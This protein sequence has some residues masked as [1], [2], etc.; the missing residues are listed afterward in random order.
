MAQDC[1]DHL[2]RSAER[3]GDGVG[4]GG[5]RVR[6]RVVQEQAGRQEPGGDIDAGAAR[7]AQGLHGLPDPRVGRGR[8]GHANV[9]HLIRRVLALNVAGAGVLL[10][11]VVVAARADGADRDPVPHGLVLTGIVVTV[12]VTAVA[13]G[14]A[15][16][17]EQDPGDPEGSDDTHSPDGHPS[18]GPSLGSGPTTAD[19]PGGGR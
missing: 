8:V 18:K 3:I 5:E 14:L 10:T 17:I 9:R 15:R 2:G 13:L 12:S 4:V 19:P 1:R 11:L 6:G 7:G 16:R